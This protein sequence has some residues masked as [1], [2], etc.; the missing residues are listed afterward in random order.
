MER[1]FVLIIMILCSAFYTD[2]RWRRNCL[3]RSR[4]FVR[5]C[6]N[7]ISFSLKIGRADTPEIGSHSLEKYFKYIQ[8]AARTG[9][10]FILSFKGWSDKIWVRLICWCVGGKWVFSQVEVYKDCLSAVIYLSGGHFK[11]HIWRCL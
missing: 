1:V 7:L 11:F 2:P 10:W 5:S 4:H 6:A 9:E 8:L 3:S